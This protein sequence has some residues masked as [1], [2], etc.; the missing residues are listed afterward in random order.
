MSIRQQHK[1]WKIYAVLQ[2]EEEE[3]KMRTVSIEHVHITLTY[4]YNSFCSFENSKKYSAIA[5]TYIDH[6]HSHLQKYISFF[7]KSE[8]PGRWAAVWGWKHIKKGKDSSSHSNSEISHFSLKFMY[9]RKTR[10]H[11]CV[12]R[13]HICA[14]VDDVLFRL[15]VSTL[16]KSVYT[17][18]EG[19]IRWDGKL[20][21]YTHVEMRNKNLS[22]HS[23]D[24]RKING[25]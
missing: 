22:R 4:I 14:R 17:L 1:G 2:R 24:E 13:P 11:A 19:E 16:R 10:S 20:Y 3:E 9:N 15:F 5:F 21:I 23:L 8:S 7:G 12:W 6:T 18:R 25:G